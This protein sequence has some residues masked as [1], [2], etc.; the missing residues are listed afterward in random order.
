[1]A[2]HSDLTGTDLHILHAYEYATLALMW[3]AT[4]FVSTDVGK[5]ARV[6]ADETLWVLTDATNVVWRPLN[7]MGFAKCILDATSGLAVATHG[8]DLEIPDNAVITRAFYEVLTTFTSAGDAATIALGVNT[9]DASG[10]VAAIAI[11]DGTNPWDAGLHDGVPDGAAAN[12]TTKTTGVRE[13]EA[14]VGVEALTDGLLHLFIEY[15]V[16]A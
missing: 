4:G 13:I 1:M 8:M 10:I 9:D 14:V 2:V 11:S 5:V 15:V 3:A 6:T 12:M 16:T 7:G